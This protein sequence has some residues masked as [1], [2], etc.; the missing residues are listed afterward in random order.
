[1]HLQKFPILGGRTAVFLLL[2]LFIELFGFNFRSWESLTYQAVDPDTYTVTCSENGMWTGGDSLSETSTLSFGDSGE[3]YLEI[4]GLQ[5]VISN[6]YFPITQNNTEDTEDTDVS[7]TISAID[8]GNGAYYSLPAVKVAGSRASDPYIRL[9]LSGRAY[10][11]KITCNNANGKTFSLDPIG[12]NVKRPFQI[13]AK[14]ILLMFAVMLTLYF[15]RPGSEIYKIPFSAAVRG[16][17]IVL[18]L[19]VGLELCCVLKTATWNKD[20]FNPPWITHQQYALL[21]ESM[22][23]GHFDLDLTPSEELLAMEN[24]YDLSLRVENQVEYW[25]DVAFYEGRYY[26]YFGVVPVLLFYL[27]YYLITGTAFSTW[28]GI[29]ITMI[30]MTIGIYFLLKELVR[31]YFRYV[32]LGLFLLLDLFLLMGSGIFIV[33]AYAKFYQFPIAMGIAFTIWGLTLWLSSDGKQIRKLVGG[34]LC[35]ALVAGC[36]PQLLVG[37]FLA[38]PLFLPQWYEKWK[39]K[40]YKDVLSRMLPALVPFVVVAAFLMYY[41]AAR[42]GSPFD[43]GANYNLTSNDMTHRGLHL[44]RIWLGIYMYFLQPPS[45]ATAFP[46]ITYAPSNIHYQGRTI[47]EAMFGGILWLNPLMFVIFLGKKKRQLLKRKKVDIFTYLCIAFGAI[48]ILLDTEMAGILFRY[49]CDF[50]IF[51][52]IGAVLLLLSLTDVAADRK[53]SAKEVPDGYG[54]HRLV[55]RWQKIIYLGCALQVLLWYLLVEFIIYNKIT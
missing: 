25:W 55:L 1:M 14:R 38:L 39:Q 42:F 31:K 11:L 33:A 16:Q 46:F 9:N 15:F 29:V 6:L 17:K 53:S 52:S 24:P 8:D 34:S 5:E 50:G 47:L 51:F 40:E 41:N 18:F 54:N 28:W 45:F 32:S 23:E 43:F 13:S 36:R 27:P 2:T 7:I 10:S 44:D 20:Y 21:A 26:V 3:C 49:V 22:T 35:M 30:A 37:S 4:T 19:L 12:L 48:L